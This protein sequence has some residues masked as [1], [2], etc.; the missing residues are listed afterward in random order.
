MRQDTGNSPTPAGSYDHRPDNAARWV[1]LSAALVI[2]LAVT[3]QGGRMANRWWIN[4]A[5]LNLANLLGRSD[6]PNSWLHG[7]VDGAIAQPADVQQIEQMIAQLDHIS[8][9]HDQPSVDRL[10][11]LA[12]LAL[13]RLADSERSLSNP[14][15]APRVDPLRMLWLGIVQERKGDTASAMVTWGEVGAV[16]HLTARA[17]ALLKQGQPQEAAALAEQVLSLCGT[18]SCAETSRGEALE[19]MGNAYRVS[20]RPDLAL[21]VYEEAASMSPAKAH[22]LAQTYIELGQFGE[23]STLLEFLVERDPGEPNYRMTLAQAYEGQGLVQQ[24]EQQYIAAATAAVAVK[25]QVSI[26]YQRLAGFYLR[27]QQYLQMDQ[28]MLGAVEN[29][30]ERVCNQI[31]FWSS[32][33]RQAGRTSE[34]YQDAVKRLGQSC[35]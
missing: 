8:T 31:L 35:P 34:L 6:L 10:R 4:S 32:L 16:G 17:Q 26:A 11:G 30:P 21:G 9:A 27:Q 3:F 33:L 25:R 15:D 24:A 1:W 14:G 23:A 22:L 29:T 28:A 2:L 18:V 13:G 12:F 5:Y 7:D 19:I 20:G